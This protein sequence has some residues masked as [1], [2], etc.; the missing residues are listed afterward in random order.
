MA[1]KQDTGEIHISRV[2]QAE[3]TFF[4]R[5]T[6]PLICNRVS[7]KT[8]RELLL[9]AGRKTAADKAINLKHDPLAEYQ[10]SPYRNLADDARTR[11]QLLSA[12]FK[13][14]MMT[15]ALDSPGAKRTQIGR[16]LYV[17]ND[18][19][20]VYGK[21][22]L[23]M[24]ITRSAD[25]NRTPDVRSRA[26]LREWA[27][28][29]TVRFTTPMIRETSVVNLLVAAGIQAGVGD[30]RVEKGAGSYGTFEPVSADDADWKR[31]AKIGREEQ[32]AA[33]ASP[34]F[35]DDETASLYTWFESELPKRGF[36]TK[37]AGGK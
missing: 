7:E 36:K 11:L 6:A 1:T 24:A 8:Q 31:I 28:K 18:R 33:L 13:K 4:I 25:M 19:V 30:Y 27:C 37:A 9:P 20:D 17:V 35:Y 10:A 26:I 23:F 3:L 12:M 22:E 15:A 16:L 21:P 32:D 29:L 2:E 5:G 34:E 14:A